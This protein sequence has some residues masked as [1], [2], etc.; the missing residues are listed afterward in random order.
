MKVKITFLAATALMLALW[1]CKKNSDTPS[2]QTKFTFA[3]TL[4]GS[5]EVP[6]NTSTAT[7]S[8]SGS[9][10]SVTKVLT[11]TVTYSGLTPTAGHI[12]KA[13]AGSNGGVVFG[14]TT[15]TPSPFTYTTIALTQAQQD[16]LF[17]SL[18]YVNLHTSTFAGGEI[19]GQLLK[20]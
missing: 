14:F 20:Q 17:N 1:S 11:V 4:S 7:G 18:Y 19:R 12:H 9:Y 13:A 15:L 6:S 8:V 16:D 3:T 2:P 5:N 10:D